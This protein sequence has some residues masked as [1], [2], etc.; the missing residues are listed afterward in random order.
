LEHI[1]ASLLTIAITLG[2]SLAG[3]IQNYYVNVTDRWMD[4]LPYHIGAFQICVFKASVG[5]SWT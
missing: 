5:D 1:G 3:N 2:I 4:D